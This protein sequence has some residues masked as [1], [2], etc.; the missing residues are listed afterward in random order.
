MSKWKLCEGC[1]QPML[2][3]GR[4]KKPGEFD[5]ARGCPLDTLSAKKL[6]DAQFVALL[7][8]VKHGS[9]KVVRRPGGFWTIA[10]MTNGRP[11]VPLWHTGTQTVMAMERAGLVKRAGE[12]PNLQYWA[13]PR[14]ITPAGRAA[15]DAAID[16]G[17]RRRIVENRSLWNLNDA[18]KVEASW[19]KR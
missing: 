5:H 3:K 7:W 12:E 4:E 15:L 2:P 11:G 14:E 13:A 18:L 9:G 6:S 17:Q 10:E 1:G 19:G 8:T 16:G